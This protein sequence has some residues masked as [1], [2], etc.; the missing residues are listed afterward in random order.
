MNKPTSGQAAEVCTF[1]ATKAVAGSGGWTAGDTL[2]TEVSTGKLVTQTTGNNPV[3]IAMETVS[4][5]DIGA[6]YVRP[7]TFA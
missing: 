4:A 2:E 7:V 6:C 3:A 1:G 5:G